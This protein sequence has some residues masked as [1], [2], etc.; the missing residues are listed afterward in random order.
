MLRMN[1]EVL[2]NGTIVTTDRALLTSRTIIERLKERDAQ[3]A[4]ERRK[5]MP[6]AQGAGKRLEK[7]RGATERERK[8]PLEE[9][10]Y[11]VTFVG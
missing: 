11:V 9:G 7:E 6:P 1:G 10:G 4:E 8:R 2:R 5:E 3:R